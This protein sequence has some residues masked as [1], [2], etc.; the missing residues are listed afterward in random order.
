MHLLHACWAFRGR[1]GTQHSEHSGA[2]LH[3]E[4]KTLLTKTESGSASLARLQPAYPATASGDTGAAGAAACR[5]G[6]ACTFRGEVWG[7]HQGRHWVAHNARA[8]AHGTAALTAYLPPC[9]GDR[10]SNRVGSE[11]GS[12]RAHRDQ[13]FGLS[14]QPRPRRVGAGGLGRYLGSQGEAGRL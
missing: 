11:P 2:G 3:N 10:V 14:A 12:M 1:P 5:P 6:Q 8:R 13:R 9:M 4:S 7:G